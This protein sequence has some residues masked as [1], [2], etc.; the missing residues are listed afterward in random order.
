[1]H[2]DLAGFMGTPGFTP[3]NFYFRNIGSADTPVKITVE[4]EE[5]GE[6]AIRNFTAHSGPCTMARE[7]E[8]GVVLINP[9]YDEYSFNLDQLFPDLNGVRR[10]QALEKDIERS[11]DKQEVLSYNNG[12]KINNLSNVK[13]PG[14]NALFLI[15]E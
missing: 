6:F 2:N 3:L 11:R 4:V 8:N 15:K 13:V 14:L 5:Q 12:E 10:I 9:S 7:F 1:M